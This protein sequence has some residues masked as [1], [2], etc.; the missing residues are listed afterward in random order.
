MEVVLALVALLQSTLSLVS[1]ALKD[2]ALPDET[3]V[4][5][6]VGVLWLGELYVT[7]DA[8]LVCVFLVSH[9]IPCLCA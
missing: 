9:P 8:A 2:L 5:D 6:L 7:L 4:N 3:L 1:L